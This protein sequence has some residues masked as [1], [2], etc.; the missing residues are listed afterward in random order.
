M[1]LVLLFFSLLSIYPHVSSATLFEGRVVRVL[2]GD[3]IEVLHE[4]NPVRVRL[5]NID[6]PEKKQPF[7]SWSTNQLKAL[8][9]G[10]SVTVSYTEKDRYGRVLG[11]VMT[12]N[13][14]EANRQQVLKGAA[15]V[16]DR[17]NTDNSL[18]ALQ[19]EAQTEK[20]G[21]WADNQPVPPWEWRH[22]K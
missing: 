8:L 9:V 17:Y 6:A 20:R 19:R 10:Q 15:W 1:K 7:G 21:L 3:T 2:D 14:T 16:Y 18:P 5:L 12:A 11:R 4:Q 13:G 22:K